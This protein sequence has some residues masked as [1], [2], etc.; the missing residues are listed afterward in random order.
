MT[1]DKFRVKPSR[2]KTAADNEVD[3]ITFRL[4]PPYSTRVVETAKAARVHP[5]QLAR[6]ATMAM[7][8]Q[9]FLD[10]EERLRRLE[11]VLI[12]FRRDFN[13]AIDDESSK[14]KA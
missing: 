3:K 11:G 5:N 10:L 8:D 13:H 1:S 7:V 6:L 9:G 4:W 14:E 2:Q 12:Q